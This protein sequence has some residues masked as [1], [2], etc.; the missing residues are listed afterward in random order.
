MVVNLFEL[1][2]TIDL[3][4][5]FRVISEILRHIKQSTQK[6]LNNKISTRSSRLEFESD[7]ITKPKAIKFVAKKYCLIISNNGNILHQL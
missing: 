2:L 1:I 3:F 5:I 7:N 6:A 4:D